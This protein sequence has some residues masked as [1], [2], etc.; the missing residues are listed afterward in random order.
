[1][2]Y[3]DPNVTEFETFAQWY[4]WHMGVNQWLPDGTHWSL[5]EREGGAEEDEVQIFFQCLYRDMYLD[6]AKYSI[7]IEAYPDGEKFN[8]KR[9]NAKRVVKKEI[10]FLYQLAKN[11]R[12]LE[13]GLEVERALYDELAGG[14][15]KKIDW[16][17][18]LGALKSLGLEIQAGDVVRV[19]SSRMPGLPAG[20]GR[21]AQAC[22]GDRVHGLFH[23]QR[24]DLR[25]LGAGF[26][27]KLDDLLRVLPEELAAGVME[28]DAV[29]M[30]KNY[31]RKIEPYGDFGYRITYDS[32]AGVVAYI[33]VHS[34]E[35]EP[36]YMYVRWVLD[37]EQSK[38]LFNRLNST[39]PE[40]SAFLFENVSRCDP[41]CVP[42]FGATSP[43]QCIARIPI[44]KEGRVA[45]ACKDARYNQPSEL[46]RDFG[47]VQRVA[48]VV[49]EVLY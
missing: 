46:S 41:A 18:F 33:H 13:E 47:Y 17:G 7:P 37:A 32:K 36:V 35:N 10:E 39:A 19:T 24:G 1:M 26:G 21:L 38:D 29:F 31:R 15:A 12:R 2:M 40:F 43:E 16:T 23:F 30:E 25:S 14:I 28:T 34:Y 9:L 44:E 22:A 20:L 3:F 6:P 27:L 48:R 11:G 8:K 4:V 49:R 5:K 42:G 45:F